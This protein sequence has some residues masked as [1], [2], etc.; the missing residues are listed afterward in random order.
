MTR[1]P[2]PLALS[3]AAT[4]LLAACGVDGEPQA[5]AQTGVTISGEAR[6]G[7]TN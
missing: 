4:L 5:P 7:V 1:K 2:L 6:V 3:L